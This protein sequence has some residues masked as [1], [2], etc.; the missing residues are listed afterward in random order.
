MSSCRAW[1]SER[2]FDADV[3]ADEEQYLIEFFGTDYEDFKARV[4]TGIPFIR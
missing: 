4:G 2:W 1:L 3:C